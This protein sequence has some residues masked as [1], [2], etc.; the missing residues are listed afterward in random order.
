MSDLKLPAAYTA[1]VRAVDNARGPVE[2][3]RAGQALQ[4]Q[5]AQL[6]REQRQAAVQTQNTPS[7]YLS[8]WVLGALGTAQDI[9]LRKAP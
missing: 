3:F 6:T 4:K 9:G 5:Y 1:S 8:W 2:G 7:K